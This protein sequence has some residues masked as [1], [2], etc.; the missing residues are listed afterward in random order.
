MPR[1]SR[2]RPTSRPASFYTVLFFVV[3]PFY[4]APAF[5]WALVLHALLVGTVWSYT[6]LRKAVFV[7][8]VLEAIFSIYYHAL[9]RRVTATPPSPPANLHMMQV[10][11]SRVL[12]AGMANLPDHYDK[13]YHTGDTSHDEEQDA[14]ERGCVSRPGSPDETIIQLDFHDPRAR[15][16]REYMRTWFHKKPWSHIHTHEMRQWLYW[17]TF[18]AHLPSESELSPLHKAALDEGLAMIQKRAGASVKRG[19][20]SRCK[21]LLLTLDEV[22]VHPRPLAFYVLVWAANYCIRTYFQHIWGLKHGK[23]GDLEYLVRLP[24]RTG[25]SPAPRPLVFIHGL[26]LGLL[27][28]HFLIRDFFRVLPSHPILIPLQPHISQNIFHPRFLN[29]LH[30]EESVRCMT[31]IFKQLGWE[32]SGVTMLSHSNGSFFHAWLLKSCPEFIR[33]SC[34]VDPVTFCSWEGDVCYNFV[35]RPCLTGIELIMRYFVSTELGVANVIQRHF[36]WFANS[37]WYEEIP[38]ATDPQRTAFFL[39]GED[40]IVDSERVKRY[41]RSHGIRKGLKFDPKG[42]H[43]QAL[44]ADGE[45]MQQVVTWLLSEI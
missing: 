39:G 16:F 25:V 24:N 37:L 6:P 4:A 3:G 7:W 29:P 18:N 20:N 14:R 2:K 15:D 41:L 5:A 45:S 17:S 36:D 10:A 43:G 30:R 38:H 8:A 34:F 28:Y 31:Q 27:Q 32:K 35:Y 23:C 44:I 22:T 9:A 33:R 12:K 40:A 19:S 13:P 26:G 21:P 1:L 11:F 42:R